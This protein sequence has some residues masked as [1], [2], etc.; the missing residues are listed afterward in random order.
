MGAAANFRRRLHVAP[1]VAKLYRDKLSGTKT[2]RPALDELM[3]DARKRRFGI[4]A[5]WRI[6]RL[7]RSVSHLLQVLETFRELEIEFV[8]IPEAIDTSSA[9]GK[10]VFTVLNAVADLER[11][12]IAE[13]VRMGLQNARKKGKRLGRPPIKTLRYEYRNG[14]GFQTTLFWGLQPFCR[15]FSIYPYLPRSPIFGPAGDRA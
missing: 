3:V 5:V 8:S 12:L 10:M 11:S 9:T 6:D 13:R 15:Y 14:R 7:G 2:S 4:V 1:D